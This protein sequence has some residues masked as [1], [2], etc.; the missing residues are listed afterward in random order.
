MNIGVPGTVYTR[1]ALRVMVS[2]ESCRYVLCITH[3]CTSR[4]VWTSAISPGFW[5]LWLFLPHV[6]YLELS[7]LVLTW[8][9]ILPECLKTSNWEIYSKNYKTHM[10]Q[11]SN[12]N[13]NKCVFI[14]KKTINKK[15]ATQP[16][17]S[18]SWS[19]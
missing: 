14:R 11:K 17:Y 15:P 9:V 6:L 1:H 18:L 7:L 16:S 13:Q 4:T 10:E 2:L 3:S 12:S 5:C 19:G 8:L